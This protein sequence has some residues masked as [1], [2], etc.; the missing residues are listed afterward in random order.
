MHE[1]RTDEHETPAARYYRGLVGSWRGLFHLEI[2]DAVAMRTSAAPLLVRLG[3]LAVA[4]FPRLGLFRIETLLARDDETPGVYVH[5]TRIS[6]FGLTAYS[7]SERLVLA[8]DGRSL[9]MTGET[10]APFTK[11]ERYD[12]TATIPEDASGATYTIP[13]LGEDLTQRTRVV[14]EGLELSQET[15]WSK[16]TVLLRRTSPATSDG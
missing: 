11:P 2:T 6:R 8:A 12:A 7:T 15:R 9:A 3:L 16:A 10:S 14:P 13:W 1:S 5:T 4:F